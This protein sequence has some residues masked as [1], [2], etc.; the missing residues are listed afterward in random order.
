VDLLVYL[1]C[2]VV[3]PRND[4]KRIKSLSLRG[5]NEMDNEAIRLSKIKNLDKSMIL[6]VLRKKS[7]VA[8]AVYL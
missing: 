4:G 1:D 6:S 3:P 2:F 7:F 5:G 8:L